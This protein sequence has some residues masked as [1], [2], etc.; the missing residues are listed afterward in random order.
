MTPSKYEKALDARVLDR[1]QLIREVEQN[2]PWLRD[3]IYLGL[4]IQ[5]VLGKVPTPIA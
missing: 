2:Y 3:R 4:I 1:G 5:M